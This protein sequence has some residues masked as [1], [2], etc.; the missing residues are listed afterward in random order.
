MTRTIT[1]SKAAQANIEETGI[2]P[3]DDIDAIR[4]GDTTAAQLLDECL[5]G[6]DPDR[7]QGWREYVDAVVEAAG[8][9][10]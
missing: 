7:A 4:S 2:D 10:A 6:A 3:M 5:D 9:P 1:F 8:R